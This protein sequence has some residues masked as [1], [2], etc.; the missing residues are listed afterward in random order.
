MSR[1][2]SISQKL[3]QKK[4]KLPSFI[5]L[6]LFPS[7]LFS[8]AFQRFDYLPVSHNGTQLRYPW[9][10]GLNSVQFGKVDVN[11]DGKKDL[12]AY[13]KSNKKYCVFLTQSNNSI[14]YKYENK[15]AAYFPP[16]SGWF[17]LK[18][19]NCDG[20][21]DIFTYNGVANAMV[22]TG[23]Y[24]G[25][26]LHY[27]LQQDGFFYQSNSGTINVYCSDVIKPAIIDVN[28]DGD[29]DLISFNV[30]G[31]R[32][33]Y[34]ENQQ[35]EKGLAC[36]SLFFT[37]ADNCWGNVRDSFAASYALKDTCSFK[38][39]RL[40]GTEQ[41]LHTGSTIEAIDID[42]NGA[43]DLLIGSV[44]LDNLTMLYNYGSSTYASILLQDVTFP[45]YNTP[46]NTKSFGSPVFLDADNN[47]TSDLL[48]STFDI[49]AANINNI[50][51]FKNNKTNGSRAIRLEFQQK[52]FL[53]DNMIDAGENSNPCFFDVD[54]DGL[55]DILLGSG[56]FRDYVNPDV[57]KLLFYKNTGDAASP[58]FDLQ[59]DD[60]LSL[61]TFNVKDIVPAAGDMDNDSDDD[62]IAG[63]SDGRMIYWENTA[64]AGNAPN[65]IYKGILKDSSG[66]NIAVG[67]NAAPYLADVNRDGKTDLIIGERNGNLNFYKGNALSAVKFSLVTDSLGGIK[68]KTNGFALGY[69]QPC[70][71]DINNDNK[72]DLILGTNASGLQFYDNI[73]DHLN[74]NFSL[75]SLVVD[76]YLGSRTTSTIADIT[77]DGKPELLTGNID[78]GLIIFSQNPPPFI[79]TGIRNQFTEKLDF[80]VYPNPV[81]NVLLVN[82]NGLKNNIQLQ[83]FNLVGQSVFSEKYSN[84]ESIELNTNTLSNGMYLLKISDGKKEG[85]RKVI[86]QH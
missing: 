38:F 59:N 70:I 16:V 86:I 19:Y 47:G 34:Y 83:L 39:N 24:V 84:Q 8:Q 30:F 12:V 68:I 44:S 66:N 18:D 3:Q 75:T 7:L 6:I 22:Y 15:Y 2:S 56:G 85:V 63:L 78:G 9:T 72:F 58:K 81:N 25:D 21:E 62:L 41:I 5:F 11:L 26:T 61:S 54:G 52:N 4:Y 48:V 73:E 36:D 17:I 71:A 28:N 77:N 51:Y 82:L 40:N 37:K 49:G 55:K 10:G 69:T 42:N 13:D 32:L 29:L 80:D 67:S 53:L 60:F 65:L 33:I 76:D 27:K 35:K 46:Y 14:N 79:P 50:W 31:N 64:P 20:I 1:Y 45:N 74:E 23:Y 57:F 43:K